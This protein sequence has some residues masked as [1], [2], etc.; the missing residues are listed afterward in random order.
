MAALMTSVIEMPIKVAEY[1][2]VCRKMNIKILPPD[3]NRGAYG[4]SVDN[5]AIRY[6]LSAIKSVGRPVINAWWKRGRQTENTVLS[7]ILSRD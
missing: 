5:G 6:G 1:I 2:Q 3:V 7:K 4:F